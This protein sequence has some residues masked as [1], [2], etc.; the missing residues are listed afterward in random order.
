MSG[1]ILG[2][3]EGATYG[4]HG[5]AVTMKAVGHQTRGQLC[6][7]EAMYPPGLS[8]HEHVHVGE[9]EMFYLLSGQL[10]VRCDADSWM[11]T[12]GGFV[13]VPRDHPHAF[14]VTGA[15]PAR[16]LVITGP[17]RLDEQIARRA[18]PVPSV[19]LGNVRPD[20]PL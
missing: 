9:D 17:P 2:P 15:E 18:E 4:F 13:F 10:S 20:R 16:A 6:V 19:A 5:S 14:S 12:A 11:V 1:F 3:G 8:V 7:M